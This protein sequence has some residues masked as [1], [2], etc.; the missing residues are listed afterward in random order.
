[1]A[2]VT[3]GKDGRFTGTFTAKQDGTWYAVYTATSGYLD[4][5]PAGDYVDVR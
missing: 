5:A 4:T 1:M 3:T 2:T